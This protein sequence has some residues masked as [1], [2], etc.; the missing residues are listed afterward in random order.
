MTTVVCFHPNSNY[1]NIGIK[2]DSIELSSSQFVSIDG[3][4][5]NR[6]DEPVAT[7][8]EKVYLEM[9]HYEKKR[10]FAT[11]LV[12]QFLNW[13]RHLQFTVFIRCEC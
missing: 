8:E 5:V 13:K 1:R 2:N 4:T 12:N 3:K 10:C 11:S 7:F 9:Y 6:Y